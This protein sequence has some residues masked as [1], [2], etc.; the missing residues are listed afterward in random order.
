[1]ANYKGRYC[2][3]F[4]SRLQT[5]RH[6]GRGNYVVE[7]VKDDSSGNVRQ[8][9]NH[10]FL[11][12]I[13]ARARSGITFGQ[14]VTEVMQGQYNRPLKGMIHDPLFDFEDGLRTHP[15]LLRCRVRSAA[16]EIFEVGDRGVLDG[17][18]TCKEMG[19]VLRIGGDC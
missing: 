11:P 9:S 5:H 7:E 3:R 18:D 8:P 13:R 14:Q 17:L 2:R 6:R 16:V 10:P 15:C 4:V 1:M 19:R 12:T